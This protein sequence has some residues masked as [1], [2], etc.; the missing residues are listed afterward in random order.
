[1]HRRGI[2]QRDV[3]FEIF[4]LEDDAGLVCEPF[5]GNPI[6]L[7]IDGGD[8]PTV[9]VADLIHGVGAVVRGWRHGEMKAH[10]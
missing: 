9:A 5:G 3:F 1:M 2:A 7:S 4:G 6:P 10:R 8:A